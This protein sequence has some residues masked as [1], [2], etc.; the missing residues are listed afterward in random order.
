MQNQQK[1]LL[2]KSTKYFANCD[3]NPNSGDSKHCLEP[4]FLNTP[5]FLKFCLTRKSSFL[6][7]FF[8]YLFERLFSLSLFRSYSFELIE[9]NDEIIDFFK[10]RHPIYGLKGFRKS[11]S[12]DIEDINLQFQD[13]AEERNGGFREIGGFCKAEIIF[14]KVDD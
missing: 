13:L 7:F 8:L 5:H 14:P 3:S 10:M 1:K 2:E 6:S 4:I 12:R 11:N 9:F